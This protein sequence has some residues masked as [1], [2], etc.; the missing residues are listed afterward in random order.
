MD[1]FS[2]AELRFVLPVEADTPVD[3]S[4]FKAEIDQ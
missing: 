3:E 2:A 1:I 4:G